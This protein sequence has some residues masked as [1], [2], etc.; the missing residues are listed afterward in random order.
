MVLQNTNN[1]G[2]NMLRDFTANEGYRITVSSADCRG[3]GT[4]CN[5]PHE[6]IVDDLEGFTKVCTKDHL[7]GTFTDYYRKTKNFI[8]ADAL[9]MDCD[10]DHSDE[11]DDWKNPEDVREAFGDVPFYVSYSRNHMKDKKGKSARPRFHIIFL[12][13][14]MDNARSYA[15]LK[16]QTQKR[17]PFFDK[18]ALDAA[19]LFFGTE[20]PQVAFYEG[21]TTL[22]AYLQKSQDPVKQER[23]QALPSR[24]DKSIPEGERNATLYQFAVKIL[25]RYGD[26]ATA[27]DHYLSKTLACDPPLEVEEIDSIWDSAEKYF[28]TVIEQ[29]EGYLPPDEYEVTYGYE[30]E[31]YSDV[32]QA[33]VL[34]RV[35]GNE[36][37]FTTG[38]GFLRYNGVI[39]EESRQRAQAAAQ[40]LTAVQLVEARKKILFSIKGLRASGAEKLI[41]ELGEKKA[42]KE[43]SKGQQ[44]AYQT[45][46]A[47]RSYYQ[48]VVKRRESRNITAT[49]KEAQPM[50]EMDPAELDTDAY[51][52][53]TPEYT[54]DL[55]KGM[56]GI[57]EHRSEDFITKCTMCSPSKVGMHQWRDALKLFFQDDPEL[58]SYV[59]EIVGL[60]AVGRV[61]VEFLIMAHGGGR[62]GKSTFWNTISAVLG[63]YSGKLSA[64]TLTVGCRRNVKPELAETKG[65][66]LL[67]A[68][69][70]EE[71]TRLNTATI[72][73][74]CSTDE[75]FAEKKYKDPFKF[76]P[77]HTLVLYTNHLPKVG[78][79]DPGTWRRL[80]V[81]PFNATIEGNDDILNYTQHL[82][83][84]CGGAVLSWIIEGAQRIIAKNFKLSQPACVVKAIEAYR[85]E[86]DWLGHFLEDRCEVGAELL[87]KSGELYSA[88]RSYCG[89][90]GEYT[91]STSDFYAALELAEFTRTRNKKGRFIKG[92]KL[93]PYEYEAIDDFLA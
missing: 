24:D 77:S 32:G 38:T 83:D 7:L 13:D 52:L 12:I 31:D 40:E 72:K 44:E 93:K 15:A 56:K 91:R 70:L 20:D 36:V 86:N 76:T 25:K 78:A 19:R 85:E 80:V 4:N 67:I 79:N 9:G 42:E 69:E 89:I 22:N 33:E 30:P 39:W 71:G 62:N 66:R 47:A 53:N 35:F 3:K 57:Q 48:F 45:Y 90:K 58:E 50:L 18:Q 8:S 68:S 10:N 2:K 65:K 21:H 28:H 6:V 61:Y 63:S 43:F 60:A 41:V 51:L 55:R 17:F 37:R 23:K 54:I 88:Y 1:R 92:L 11:P 46:K 87:Q 14:P 73:Q 29:Q 16:R 81:V 26:T 34:E 27:W 49:L 84:T 82:I 5:F 74:F 75:I 64:D 59:Q